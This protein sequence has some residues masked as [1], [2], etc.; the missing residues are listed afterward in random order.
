MLSDVH[1][2]WGKSAWQQANG[3]IPCF[4]AA[5]L[6]PDATLNWFAQQVPPEAA[7]PPDET[8]ETA[9]SS[10]LRRLL[11]QRPLWTPQHL[12]E[13]LAPEALPPVDV[14]IALQNLTYRFKSGDILS[15]DCMFETLKC[16]GDGCLCLESFCSWGIHYVVVRTVT[17]C[18]VM[19]LVVS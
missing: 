19:G 5:A 4:A 12:S 11:A 17:V 8:P 13:A 15:Q 18:F 14:N 7:A 9:A 3:H 6:E 10:S 16:T 2:I 1:V